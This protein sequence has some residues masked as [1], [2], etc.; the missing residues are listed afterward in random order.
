MEAL[1]RLLDGREEPPAC[2]GVVEL[3]LDAIA[4]DDGGGGAPGKIS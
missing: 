3:D 2:L 4:A 1:A